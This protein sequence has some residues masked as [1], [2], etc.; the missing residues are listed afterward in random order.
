[1]SRNQPI[2]ALDREGEPTSSRTAPCCGCRS[3]CAGGPFRYEVGYVFD[4]FRTIRAAVSRR[5]CRSGALR[6]RDGF[7]STRPSSFRR[8]CFSSR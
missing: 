4:G 2:G 7:S 5:R 3:A 6:V 8:G 1:V